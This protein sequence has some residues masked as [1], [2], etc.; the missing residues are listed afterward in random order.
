MHEMS[1]CEGVLQILED[2]A[3]R[4]D[5]KKVSKVRLEV[6]ALAVVEPDALRFSFDVVMRGTVAEGAQLEIVNVDAEAWCFDCCD[7]VPIAS[8]LDDCPRCNGSRLKP[9]RGDELRIKDL[10]VA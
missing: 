2:E 8:R 4:H 5:F 7:T 10:E 1:L 6:G 3:R 9:T